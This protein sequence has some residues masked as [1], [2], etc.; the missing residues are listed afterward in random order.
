M[1]LS[2]R[3]FNIARDKHPLL[4]SRPV[5]I[6]LHLLVT[7]CSLLCFVNSLSLKPFWNY[8]QFLA[9]AYKFAA[10]LVCLHNG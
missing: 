9:F 8:I 2:Y 5:E 7:S 3:R 4:P 6:Q 10:D 1:K